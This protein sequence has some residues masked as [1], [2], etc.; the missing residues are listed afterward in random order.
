V[1][2]GVVRDF[3]TKVKLH[4]QKPSFTN[5][6]LEILIMDNT[7][8]SPDGKHYVCQSCKR[9]IKLGKVPVKAKKRMNFRLPSLPPHLSD[10][11]L[12]INKC[13]A[14]LLKIVL[15]FIR[16]MHIPRSADFKVKGP[17]IC[18]QSKYEDTLAELLPLDQNLIP[19]S[20]KRK[21]E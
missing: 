8:K 2:S 12:A 11:S 17:M 4:G 21:L 18:I 20:L 6:E 9:A 13:E 3:C 10:K 1:A 5:E 14:H 16:V 15:P 19:V 7:M